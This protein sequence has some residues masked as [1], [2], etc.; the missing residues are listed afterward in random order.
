MR[1]FVILTVFLVL[2]AQ[3]ANADWFDDMVNRIHEGI[4]AGADFIKEKAAPTI[5]EKF[6]AAKETLQDPE[7]H[8]GVQTWFEEKAV[9]A[10]KEKISQLS[11][12]VNAEVVPEVQKIYTAG[13]T[14]A[15]ERAKEKSWDD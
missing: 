14:A 2:A 6:N 10:V 8:R 9:P 5:R 11:E 15:E 3:H 1:S 7:T 12:F 13:K 4:T